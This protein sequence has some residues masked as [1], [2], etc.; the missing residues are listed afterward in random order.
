M[1]TGHCLLTGRVHIVPVLL[2]SQLTC[3]TAGLDGNW[4]LPADR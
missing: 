4:A 2:L 1:A 3:V